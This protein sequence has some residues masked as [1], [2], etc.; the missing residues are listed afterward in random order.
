[1]IVVSGLDESVDLPDVR[2]K[3]LDAG[4]AEDWP[5][6]LALEPDLRGDTE[7]WD[8]VWGPSI[9]VAAGILGRPGALALLAGCAD[10]GF[11]DLE[12][13]GSRY[14]E[15]AFGADPD[16]PALRARITANV[17]APRMELLRWPCTGPVLP[18][19]L[20][21]LDPDGERRLA[22]RL[23][24]RLPSA[25]ATAELMLNWVTSR[26]VHNGMNHDNSGDAN[27]VL[28]RVEA[29]ERFACL[30][31]GL[32][33]AQ[34][35]NAVQIPARRVGLYRE[36]Y[37]TGLGGA[38]AVVEAW[39]DDLGRWV[40]LDGQ[41]GAVWLDDDG[42]PL[43]VLDLQARYRAGLRPRFDGRGP[44]FRATDAAEWFKYFFT[45]QIRDA[46]AWS[47]GPY[48]PLLEGTTVIECDRL[49]SSDVDAAP[50]LAALSTGIV[51][52]DGPALRFRTDHPYP[53][54]FEVAGPGRQVTQLRIDEPLPLAAEP[55]E[56][57]LTV[58]TRTAYATL[59]PQPLR[60][61]VR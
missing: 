2:N 7:L 55:G 54:G 30:E 37:H 33:L 12:L 25:W 61:L 8:L 4:R 59:S 32:V 31:Y 11:H 34:A 40:L 10:A 41:N 52:K 28:D 51:S 17:P 16:W 44:N 49:A 9:A 47:S 42:T 6:L 1:M 50:D 18:L 35:L 27:L 48:V 45:A 53:A 14:F 5:G 3:A 38:H 20:A 13:V 60:Y 58:A 56:H 26:W 39:I 46:V 57:Q 24:G 36:G 15:A 21:R 29:G 22:A 19:G 23:P 43:G